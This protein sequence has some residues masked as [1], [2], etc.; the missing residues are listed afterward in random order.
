L[1]Y[2]ISYQFSNSEKTVDYQSRRHEIDFEFTPY[3]GTAN[4][5]FA[6]GQKTLKLK[7]KKTTLQ[8]ERQNVKTSG[9]SPLAVRQAQHG[10]PKVPLSD[11]AVPIATSNYTHLTIDTE[12]LVSNPDGT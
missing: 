1:L 12:G 5:S 9:L 3:Y 8:Y 2:I 4:L 10:S 7:Y 11:P 6:E